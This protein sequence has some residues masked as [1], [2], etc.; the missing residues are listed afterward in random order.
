MRVITILEVFD[1]DP[2]SSL[3]L[4]S[5]CICGETAAGHEL[6]TSDGNVLPSREDVLPKR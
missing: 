5:D 2:I 3:D 6:D 1:K 4:Q